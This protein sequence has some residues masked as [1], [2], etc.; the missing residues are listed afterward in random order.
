MNTFGSPKDPSDLD[1]VDSQSEV[2]APELDHSGVAEEMETNIDFE[3]EEALLASI[4]NALENDD[5]VTAKSLAGE[6]EFPPHVLQAL[7]D[8]AR[9]QVENDTVAHLTDTLDHIPE[10]I[11][12]EDSSGR[13]AA[14][15]LKTK[16]SQFVPEDSVVTEDDAYLLFSVLQRTAGTKMDE[17]VIATLSSEGDVLADTLISSFEKVGDMQSALDSLNFLRDHT[18]IKEDFYTARYAE[19]RKAILEQ[20]GVYGEE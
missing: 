3:K 6:C 13:I 17:N 12:D 11:E 8:I 10:L 5:L 2:L 7:T 20:E 15:I 1:I 19:I 18:V 16:L 9:Y 4:H 14:S